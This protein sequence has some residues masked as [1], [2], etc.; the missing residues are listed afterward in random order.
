MS[1]ARHIRAARRMS[2]DLD[3]YGRSEDCDE[4]DFELDGDDF[5][6]PDFDADH[7]ADMACNE[8]EQMLDARASQ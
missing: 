6:E 7:A 8:Y 1:A 5:T 4:D 2:L 3:E